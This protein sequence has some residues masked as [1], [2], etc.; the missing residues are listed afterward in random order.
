MDFGDAG[1]AFVWVGLDG[2]E[3]DVVEAAVDAGPLNGGD[4]KVPWGG[5]PV[6]IS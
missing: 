2:G 4:L 5:L 1:K 3:D 6:R